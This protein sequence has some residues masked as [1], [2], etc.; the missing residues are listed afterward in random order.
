MTRHQSRH[1]DAVDELLPL[2]ADDDCRSVLQYFRDATADEYTVQEIAREI[3]TQRHESEQKTAARLHHSVVPRL[4]DADI[5][6][7][8]ADLNLVRYR[9][10]DELEELQDAVTGVHTGTDAAG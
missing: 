6:D 4:A 8:D 7:Y 10:H 5:V 2:L 3:T 9:G 1:S